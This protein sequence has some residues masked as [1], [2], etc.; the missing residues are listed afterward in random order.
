[1]GSKNPAAMKITP[2]NSLPITTIIEVLSDHVR[3][4][5]QQ[6]HDAK[7]LLTWALDQQ[8]K[9]NWRVKGQPWL[10]QEVFSWVRGYCGV[11]GKP[12]TTKQI[13]E[14]LSTNLHYGI[15]S[16]TG[17]RGNLSRLVRDGLLLRPEAGKYWPADIL[18]RKSKRVVVE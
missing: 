5:E 12:V 9:F 14:A 15:G 7:L 13:V 3:S 6:A 1:M 2:E 16:P 18:L 17:I 10:A 11:H 8:D 4:L